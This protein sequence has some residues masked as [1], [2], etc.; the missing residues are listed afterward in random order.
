MPAPP[1]HTNDQCRDMRHSKLPHSS[2]RAKDE[3]GA[4]HVIHVNVFSSQAPLEYM[5]LYAQPPMPMSALNWA[6]QRKPLN[7]L[8]DAEQQHRE[9]PAEAPNMRGKIMLD[10][11]AHPAHISTPP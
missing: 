8:G 2:N 6:F 9:Q 4:P 7:S 11:A 1:N 3:P 5:Q 10:S